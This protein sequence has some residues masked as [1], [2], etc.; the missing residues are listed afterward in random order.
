MDGVGSNKPEIEHVKRIF[1]NAG[2]LITVYQ[3][4]AGPLELL[5]AIQADIDY[6]RQHYER[7]QKTLPV[8]PEHSQASRSTGVV[9]RV[10]LIADDDGDQE[11]VEVDTTLDVN[12]FKQKFGL[13]KKKYQ[14]IRVKAQNI[15]S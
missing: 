6:L 14:A 10:P 5:D 9:S 12:E 7:T 2:N 11:W 13:S 1:Q 8:R 3:R 15:G 4:N